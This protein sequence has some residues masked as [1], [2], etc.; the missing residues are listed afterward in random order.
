MSLRQLRPKS[1]LSDL[2]N[3]PGSYHKAKR[4]GR[5]PSSGKGKTSGRGQKGQKARSSVKATFEGGQTP[6]SKLFPKRGFHNPNQSQLQKLNLNRL[7][8]WIDQGRINTS[9]AITM[10]HLA[11]SRCVHGIRDGIKLLAQGKESFHSIINIEVTRASHEAIKTIEALGG[12]LKAKYYNKL[13]LRALLYPQKFARLPREALPTS[14]R[15]LKFY[16]NPRNRGSLARDVNA[17]E[18]NN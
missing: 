3:I 12:S 14:R 2:Q 6:I 15:D 10:K 13:G 8:N 16:T 4:V 5:G 7:Q 1:L 11:E 17:R 9:E 18:V